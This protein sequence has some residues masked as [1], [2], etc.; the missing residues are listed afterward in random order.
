LYK[1]FGRPALHACAVSIVPWKKTYGCSFSHLT[2]KQI[3]CGMMKNRKK[4]ERNVDAKARLVK[5][6]GE[7]NQPGG[8]N[9]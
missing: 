9:E 5:A 2:P 8:C 4:K 3:Q 1:K 6:V 7:G